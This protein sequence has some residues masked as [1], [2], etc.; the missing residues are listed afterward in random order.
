MKTKFKIIIQ[1]LITSILIA[2]VATSVF[3]S[4]LNNLKSLQDNTSI[5]KT[6]SLGYQDLVA[7]NG[8]TGLYCIQHGKELRSA[9]KLYF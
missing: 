3:A 5:G 8:N 6:Y 1:S 4:G 7:N 9:K 2:F